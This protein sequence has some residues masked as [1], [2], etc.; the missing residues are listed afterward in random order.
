[1]TDSE[2]IE[3][4]MT[5]V[6]ELLR[7]VGGVPPQ[8]PADPAIPDPVPGEG[9]VAY[10]Q[11]VARIIGGEKG[12]QAERAAGSLFLVG[13][14][15]VDKHGGNWKAAALEFVNGDPAYKPDPRWAT[16]RPGQ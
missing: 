7:R 8:Q 16:Y 14:Y 12:A 10:V 15:L 4:L 13:Q 2:K 3:Y 11:R 9:I 5:A 6:Q 1:M